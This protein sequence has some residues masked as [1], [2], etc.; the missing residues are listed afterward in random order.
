MKK[1]EGHVARGLSDA[2]GQSATWK[3]FEE[4]KVSKD[5]QILWLTEVVRLAVTQS[6]LTAN[7]KAALEPTF[8]G[9][10]DD[11]HFKHQFNNVWLPS[12]KTF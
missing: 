1:L 3:L 2:I 8:I 10:T 6:S 9:I 4:V 5:S 12:L 11:K 7:E